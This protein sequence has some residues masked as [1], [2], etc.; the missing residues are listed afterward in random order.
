[1]GLPGIYLVCNTP[2]NNVG[3][4]LEGLMKTINVLIAIFVTLFHTI[5]VVISIIVFPFFL[6]EHAPNWY[7]CVDLLAMAFFIY[8]SR[9]MWV[10]LENISTDTDILE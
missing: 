10:Y 8:H 7:F 4:K 1:M 6:S 3:I 2:G 9:V 5:G